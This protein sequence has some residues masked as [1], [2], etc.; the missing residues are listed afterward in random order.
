VKRDTDESAAPLTAILVCGPHEFFVDE[1]AEEARGELGFSEEEIER[2]AE[3]SLAARLPDALASGSL[4]SSRRLVEA[5]LSALF[6]RDAPAALAE[7]A[8]AAWEK[9]SAAGRRE[10]FKKARALLAAL[11]IENES[12]E[13]TAATAAKRVRRPEIRE[14]LEE[15]FR[16]LPGGGASGNAAA[17]AVLA[18]LEGGVPGTVLLARAVDPP[19]TSALYKA[20]DAHGSIRVAGGDDNE[21]ARLLVARARKLASQKRVTIEPAAIERLRSRTADD[22]R[23]FASELEKL[24]EWAGE[25]GKIVARDV[26]ALVEDR[27][28]EDVYAFF[29]A[30]GSRDRAETMRRL[31][32]ILS[33]RAL[34]TGEREIK[35][36]EPLRAFFGM[37]AAEI[38]RLLVV[39]ARCEETRTR[40]NPALAYGA[41]Q[42]GVHPRLSAGTPLLEGNP[43]LWY[44]AYQRA[45]RFTPPELVRA[46]R[47]CADADAATKDSASLEDTIALLVSEIV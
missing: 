5:D 42:S 46:L 2:I 23:F 25:K 33:G 19:R 10:A 12:A 1:A 17:G 43:F 18:H 26:E 16:E 34:R 4:F 14:T 30:L 44:K 45:A 22:P 31:E 20:F 13:E 24:L 7:E 15:I 38:R 32:G 3:E 39:R 36:D 28:A 11:Q 21:N 9:E 35:G 40:I 27:R 6:G 41:Y 37:L 29:D 47:R 8:A